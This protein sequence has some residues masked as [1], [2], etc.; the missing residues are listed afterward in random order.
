MVR[1]NI[2]FP[3]FLDRLRNRARQAQERL[4]MVLAEF[5]RLAAGIDP[6]HFLSWHVAQR[7]RETHGHQSRAFG[8][9]PRQSGRSRH[10]FVTPASTP[11]L[12]GW[13]PY[14]A[15]A[16]E[17]AQALLLIRQQ[18]TYVSSYH[19]GTVYVQ[20]NALVKEILLA[21]L[22]A[23]LDSG[24][25]S[26]NGL[27]PGAVHRS[28]LRQQIR[29]QTL[30]FRNPS[31]EQRL[32]GLTSA[33]FKPLDDRL[34]RQAGVRTE[35]LLSMMRTLLH[36][37]RSEVQRNGLLEASTL[38]DE[39]LGCWHVP[40]D[41]FIA[42]YPGPVT[43]SNLQ[44]ALDTWSLAFGDLKD[45]SDHKILLL[46]NPVWAK[47]FV[48]LP[49]GVYFWV[50]QEVFWHASI[51]LLEAILRDHGGKLWTDY[52]EKRR[53]IFLEEALDRRFAEAFPQAR[54]WRSSNWWRD[55]AT[56]SR[57]VEAAHGENDL[58]LQVDTWL[59]AVE[60]K[61]HQL[62]TR[63]RLAY[64]PRVEKK[65][66]ETRGKGTQQ[67]QDFVALLQQRGGVCSFPDR[68]D[69]K[70]PATNIINTTTIRRYG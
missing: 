60:A 63:A 28:L 69:P 8:P 52:N 55:E 30:L 34:E 48:R 16:R 45:T 50:L 25:S 2:A 20:L 24:L 32:Q 57:I 27:P 61:A 49:N 46:D 40:L 37:L 41:R 64:L 29:Q 13:E 17:A 11:V 54:R 33:L 21:L 12:D 39:M 62:T 68:D 1:N 4:P 66:D 58:A 5:E 53:G 47:P 65:L 22:D 26:L 10:R 67:A 38:S 42:C 6:L 35:H 3:A 7:L 51:P 19:E 70:A 18:D 36:Q 15:P 44:V 59:C 56:E 31:T 14:I 9:S 43:A 23:D